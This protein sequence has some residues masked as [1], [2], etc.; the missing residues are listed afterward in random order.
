MLL[1]NDIIITE[2]EILTNL[3]KEYKSMEN[4][5]CLSLAYVNENEDRSKGYGCFVSRYYSWE[6]PKK[7]ISEIEKLDKSII[8]TP[9][10]A[11]IFIKRDI[12]DELG[13]FDDIIPFGGDDD[14]LG[15]KSWM[16]GYKNYLYSNSLQIHI[17]L[18]E[19]TNTKKYSYKFGMKI[20]A[21]LHTITKNFKFFNALVTITLYV[22]V[23]FLK[24][25]KQSLFRFS[26]RPVKSFFYGVYLYLKNIKQS[27]KKRKEIQ[28][29][30]EV[31]KD[32]FFK[33]RPESCEK[34]VF[35]KND[36]N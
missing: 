23:F 4:C 13:G 14:D 33:I 1:D 21:H 6:K 31:K 9:Q 15:M 34:K 8:G 19:R 12:W 10:G 11:G 20:F 36:Q 35:C 26:F 16:M 27:L 30:R 29:K 3:L 22:L 17:G 2:D 32:I 25:I 7:S 24:S 5:G 18:N 28:K